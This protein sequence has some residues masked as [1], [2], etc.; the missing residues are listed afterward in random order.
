MS[1][2]MKTEVLFSR[3]LEIVRVSDRWYR[4]PFSFDVDIY[5]D[6]VHRAHIDIDRDFM[7]DGRSG[8]R[9][10][11]FF[12]PNLG[13]QNERRAW[14]IHDLLSYSL[15]ISYRENNRLLFGTLRRTCGYPRVKAGLIWGAVSLSSSYYGKPKPDEREYVNLPKIHVRTLGQPVN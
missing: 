9:I 4:I 7:F 11:D 1:V 12:V 14:F 3:D 5:L 2:S 8:P 10:V 15:G 6:G 13:T